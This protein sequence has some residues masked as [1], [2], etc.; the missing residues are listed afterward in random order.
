MVERMQD[1]L[2]YDVWFPDEAKKIR[3]VVREFAEKEIEPV[4]YALDVREEEKE[5]FP[6]DIFKKMASKGLFQ[7]PFPKEIGGRGLKYPNCCTI[8]T[9]EELAY[10]SNSIA[11]IYDVQCMLAGHALTYGSRELQEKYLRPLI[12]GKFVGCF[13]TTEP[14]ASNDLRAIETTAERKGDKWIIN[15]HK[16]FITNAP[17]GNFVCT[18]C[19]TGKTFSEIVVDLDAKGVKVGEPDKKIGNKAQL[20]ADIYFNNAEALEENLIGEVGEGLRIALGTLTYGRIGIG[21]TGVGMAQAAFDEAV[22]YM[23]ERMAF[24]K[25]LAQFQ[26]WQY[27]FAEKATQIDMARTLC[28]KAAYRM[29][30]EG[31]EFPE[32]HAAM[33]KYFGTQTAGDM[34]RDAVQIFGGYGYLIQLSHDKSERKVERIY[35]DCKIPEIYEGANEVQKFIIAR[36]IFGRECIAP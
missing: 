21:A 4:A 6:W 18:L 2:Y 5:N 27:R 10:V 19:R 9:M 1:K 29:D 3:T 35:R 34:A 7:I 30:V 12:K 33:A 14:Q 17:V 36:E 28:Y 11:A 20:T 13:A 32:P 8:V 31:V 22:S 24:G 15:G 23:K 26:Y 25:K 16:R